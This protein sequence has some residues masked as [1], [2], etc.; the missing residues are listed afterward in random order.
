MSAYL[1]FS[2]DSHNSFALR[3][4]QGLSDYFTGILSGAPEVDLERGIEQ[5]GVRASHPWFKQSNGMILCFAYCL[6]SNQC[7]TIIGLKSLSFLS[8]VFA[9]LPLMVLSVLAPVCPGSY[10]FLGCHACWAHF[11][12]LGINIWCMYNEVF[13]CK[14]MSVVLL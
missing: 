10:P 7:L 8:W 12:W 9:G 4:G 5:A 14:W 11:W 6:K 2:L 1:A 3:P 13:E